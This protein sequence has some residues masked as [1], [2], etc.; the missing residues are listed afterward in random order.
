MERFTPLR[1]KV[2]NTYGSPETRGIACYTGP[3]EACHR[4]GQ[5]AERGTGICLYD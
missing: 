1:K 2:F 4:Q 3:Q 5:E